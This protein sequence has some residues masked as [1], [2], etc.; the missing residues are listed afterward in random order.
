MKNLA[1]MRLLCACSALV[2]LFA[3]WNLAG[4]VHE[5][6][7]AAATLALGGRV[8]SLKLWFFL[9]ATNTA[10]YGLSNSKGAITLLCGMLPT[11]ALGVLALM[12]VP[13]H[14]LSAP[15]AV[16]SALFLF[17]FVLEAWPFAFEFALPP[18]ANDSELFVLYSRCD[19][20]LVSFIGLII[21]S[22][23]LWIWFSRTRFLHR[24]YQTFLALVP[25]T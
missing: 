7:H 23:S 9:G 3:G 14:R 10:T 17:D 24:F 13:W 15:V 1:A 11:N 22:G 16:V 20:L 2:A 8:T 4:A 12:V 6:G 21:L 25:M 19:D 5:L 18:V